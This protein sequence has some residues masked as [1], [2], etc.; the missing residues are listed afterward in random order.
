VNYEAIP[1]AVFT[2]PEIGK[3]GLTEDEA[4]DRYEQIQT[5]EKSFRPYSSVVRREPEETVIKLVY[6]G[7][8][9]RLVGLH[10]LGPHASEIVQGFAPGMRKGLYQEDMKDFPGI[11]P[12]IAEEI[13][14]TK[15]G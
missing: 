2:D 7:N 10:V 15:L 6:E 13:F 9:A 3:V 5:A 14:S 8:D 12:T 4:R 1:S 11:H